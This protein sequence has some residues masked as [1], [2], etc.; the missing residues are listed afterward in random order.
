[1]NQELRSLGFR[2]RPDKLRE[3]GCHSTSLKEAY[4]RCSTYLTGTLSG[5][6]MGGEAIC[7]HLGNCKALF[8]CE[9]LLLPTERESTD[10]RSLL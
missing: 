10:L 7:Q 4:V 3:F 6:V 1:M 8:K 2:L 9:G 5:F